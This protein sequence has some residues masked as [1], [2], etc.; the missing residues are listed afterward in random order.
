MTCSSAVTEIRICARAFIQG[1]CKIGQQGALVLGGGMSGQER[2]LKGLSCVFLP[3]PAS[4]I[5]ASES[6]CVDSTR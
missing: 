6:G 1:A 2:V 5:W 4:A 3:G